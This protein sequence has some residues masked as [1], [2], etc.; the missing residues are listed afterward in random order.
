M[1]DTLAVLNASQIDETSF[2]A[3]GLCCSRRVSHSAC[4]W[5]GRPGASPQR[6]GKKSDHQDRRADEG[7][8]DQIVSRSLARSARID[9]D[10]TRLGDDQAGGY[11]FGEVPGV[12]PL[13][14]ADNALY[15]VGEDWT[16]STSAEAGIGAA[17]TAAATRAQI[18]RGAILRASPRP[19]GRRHERACR[20]QK[21]PAWT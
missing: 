7:P 18:M 16:S 10:C 4:F 17:R 11:V 5:P 1:S 8:G 3:T 9:Q 19:G 15:I 14:R 13:Q 20:R 6:S 12:V 21:F 2:S